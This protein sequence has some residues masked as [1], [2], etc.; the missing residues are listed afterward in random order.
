MTIPD[1]DKYPQHQTEQTI[2]QFETGATRDTDIGK[3]DYESFLSPIVIE[4]YAQYLH[5]HRIQSDGTIRD[6]DNWQKGIPLSVYMKSAWR[7]FMMWWTEHRR[8]KDGERPR[9]QPDEIE[10]SLCAVLFNVMGYLH[11][12]L[13]AKSGQKNGG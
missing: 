1:Y 12:I 3:L 10:E 2:R 8:F 5:K 11:E 13:K 9:F 4:R 7:H 6:G